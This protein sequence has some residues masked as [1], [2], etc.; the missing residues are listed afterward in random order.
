MFEPAKMCPSAF[1]FEKILLLSVKFDQ[2][3]IPNFFFFHFFPGF[4]FT[5]HWYPNYSKFQT[6]PPIWWPRNTQPKSRRV[7]CSSSSMT[8]LET[9]RALSRWRI[10]PRFAGILSLLLCISTS[11]VKWYSGRKFPISKS[12][13]NWEK[14]FSIDLSLIFFW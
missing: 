9:A 2:T 4:Y 5:G 8:E 3:W 7:F 13:S 6:G 1:K 14:N 11:L 12:T 10:W